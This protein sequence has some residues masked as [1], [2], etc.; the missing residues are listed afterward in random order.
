MSR[1]VIIHTRRDS[2]DVEACF[3]EESLAVALRQAIEYVR[4]SA[5]FDRWDDEVRALVEDDLR[6]DWRVEGAGIHCEERLVIKRVF[7]MKAQGQGG[8]GGG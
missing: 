1:Y 2:G 8:S 3:F 6:R 7:R 5:F 4:R